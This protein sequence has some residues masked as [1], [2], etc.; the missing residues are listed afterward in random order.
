M[1]RRALDM[2]QRSMLSGHILQDPLIGHCTSLSCP[3]RVW[4]GVV[5]IPLRRSQGPA[6]FH[7]E[8]RSVGSHGVA[9][10]VPA[11]PVHGGSKAV[12]WHKHT[13]RS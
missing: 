10:P 6:L 8:T 12:P 7:M 9:G 5:G 11:T 1:L 13:Q 4:E 2:P 3:F